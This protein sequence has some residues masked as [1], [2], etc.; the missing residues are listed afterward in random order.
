MRKLLAM[1]V[2]LGLLGTGVGAASASTPRAG[3]DTLGVSKKEIKLGITYVDLSNL[4]D[5]I[6]IVL[7]DWAQMYEA[8]IA[9]LNK[10]GGV[11]GRK[12]VPVFAPVE[13]VGTVPAQEACVKLTEDEQVF[14]VTGFFLADA[15]ACYVDQHETPLVG[16]I[17][18]EELVALAKAP[19]FSLEPDDQVFR[20]VIDALAADGAFKGKKLGIVVDAQFQGL[21]DDVIEPAL[22]R[23]KVSGTVANITGTIGDDVAAEQQ[24]G[25]IAERFRS[26]GINKVLLVGTTMVQFANA[27][28]KT[29]YRPQLLVTS[30]NNLR[31]YILNAG[32]DLSVI[33]DA[34]SAGPSIDFNDPALQ[35][36]FAVVE[37]A[38]GYTIVENAPESEPQY[39]QTSQIVCRLTTLFAEIAEAAG[40]KLTRTSFGKAP[41]KVGK[42]EVPGSGTIV[43]NKKTGAFEQPVH[44]YRFDPDLQLA[45]PDEKP[46][47]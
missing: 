30:E 3:E 38:T 22:K 14:A 16:G 17:K 45:V 32:S 39:R 29:D 42:F 8:V 7:G 44:I 1:T 36:C 31:A 6:D 27:L 9:D 26:D 18:T 23:N 25:V 12:I 11:N 15:P 37:K 40:K 33:E 19:W 34:L 13:P 43:Y 2:V 35:K 28:A 46:L 21:Y 41:A 4:G 10:K 47:A 20:Q 24:S 5:S